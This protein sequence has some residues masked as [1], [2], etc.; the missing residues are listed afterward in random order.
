MEKGSD[1][2]RPVLFDLSG[3][4]SRFSAA[5]QPPPLLSFIMK[6][7]FPFS[8]PFPSDSVVAKEHGDR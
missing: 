2:V 3:R 1:A 6:R 5:L 8:L 7:D 4:F